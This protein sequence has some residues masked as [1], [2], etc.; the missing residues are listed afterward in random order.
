[1]ILDFGCG[2]GQRVHGLRRRGLQ[3]LGCDVALPQL[4]VGPLAA[5]IQQEVIRP[6][7]T[8]P[9]RLPFPDGTFDLVF[10][11]TVFD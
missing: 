10:S 4:P 9:Y 6:I 3:A 5:S 8:A 11:V 7:E 2:G 1:M